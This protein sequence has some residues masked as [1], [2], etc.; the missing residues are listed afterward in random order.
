[1]IRVNGQDPRLLCIGHR[2]AMGHV[3]ENTL[4]S[5]R[6]A[7][8][9]GAPCV[10]VDV[11]LVD[12][13]LI[14][15]HDELLDRTTNGRGP[16]S[17]RTFES[18]RRLD[19]GQREQIPTLDEVCAE[20]APR[21]GLNIEL[22]GSGTAVPV[23]GFLAGFPDQQWCMRSVLV[24]S[25]DHRALRSFRECNPAVKMGASLPVSPVDNCGFAQDLDAFSVHFRLDFVDRR[26]IDDAHAR[27]LKIYVFTVNRPEDISRMHDWGVDGVFTDYPERVVSRFVQPDLTG[28][29]E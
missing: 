9:L 18:L 24:S 14:V 16:L 13:R 6:R 7:L 22:K 5:V 8:I 23:A 28:G 26:F 25:F 3:P 20:L 17:V 12:G 2:G 29:W 21:A 19:A 15:F 10:E 11:H 4:A 1:M 27:Q